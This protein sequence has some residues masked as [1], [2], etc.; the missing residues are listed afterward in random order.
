MIDSNF[1][2]NLSKKIIEILP[3]NLSVLRDDFTNNLKAVLQSGF[4][5]LD[6]VTREEFDIQ[7]GVLTKTRAKLEKLEHQLAELEKKDKK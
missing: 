7:V 5:K 4:A 6:L 3:D 2:D 1:F